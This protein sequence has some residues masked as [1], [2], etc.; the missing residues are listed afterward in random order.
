MIAYLMREHGLTADQAYVLSS[1]AVDL[2]I[3]QVVDGQNF[4]AT[5]IVP[6]DVF[7]K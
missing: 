3:G 2:R 5:A 4:G 1:V 7:K 6:L